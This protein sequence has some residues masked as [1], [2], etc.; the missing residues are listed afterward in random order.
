[1][2]HRT[3][4]DTREDSDNL[5][6]TQLRSP[7]TRRR[8]LQL[9]AAGGAVMAT[10]CA[11][12]PETTPVETAT[13]APEAGTTPAPLVEPRKP[14]SFHLPTEQGLW[15]PAESNV[16]RLP[17]GQ[18]SVRVEGIGEF[19]FQADG[20]QTLRPDIF[21]P[22]RFSLFDV[23]VHVADLGHIS[24][25]YHFSEE[26]NTHVIDS[27]DGEESWWYTAFYSG[28]WPEG[29]AFRM[30]MFPY[31]NGMQFWLHRERGDRLTTIYDSFHQ[32]VDRLAHNGG[33]IIIPE[34]SIRS[35]KSN[36][37]YRNVEV[38]AHDVRTD[39]LQPGIVTGLDAILSLA[40]Q[41]ELSELRLTW[42]ERIGT[43]DPVDSYW[44]E[45]IDRA[46]AEGTCGFVY[47]TGA[48]GIGGN[49][50]HLPSDVRLTVSPEYALWF[51]ICL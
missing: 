15:R 28:G 38:T 40:E 30:D 26:M 13:P 44:L 11:P 17:S 2:S 27:I 41:G 39:V 10:R 47:E 48:R 19:Q 22:G 1:M 32:E 51:W 35:P 21:Q 43:A 34:V 50:I 46:E 5:S 24:L 3:N 16:A 42:Y 18:N 37:L 29:N 31:K 49:H 33:K 45:Q 14:R 12:A 9:L 23:L 6:V 20:L 4:K 8:F 25:D 36:T 7:V